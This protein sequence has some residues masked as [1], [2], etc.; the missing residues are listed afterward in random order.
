M[1]LS[2]RLNTLRRQAGVTPERRT[3]DEVV[4]DG[5]GPSGSA[6][7]GSEAGPADAAGGTAPGI[8]SGQETGSMTDASADPGGASGN[9]GSV[10]EGRAPATGQGE[11]PQRARALAELRERIRRMGAAPKQPSAQDVRHSAVSPADGK[12]DG[13]TAPTAIPNGPAVSVDELAERLGGSRIG[14]HVILL[15]RELPPGH[16]H[17]R[18]ALGEALESA[19]PFW[20]AGE[21]VGF[22]DTETTGLAGGAGT[23][24]FLV[25][26]ATP[27][28]EGLRLRQWLMTAF[29]GE[30][31]M[32]ESVDAALAGCERLVSYNGKTFDLPLL[33]DRR[34][35]QRRN[36]PADSAHTDFLHPVRA[37][38]GHAWP[39]CRL[40][41]AE[42]RLLGLQRTDDLPGSDAPWAWQAYLRFGQAD[43]LQRVV[44]HNADD[45]FSLAVLGPALA[46]V[47]AD[48]PAQLA[49][50]EGAARLLHRLRGPVEA[51]RLLQQCEQRLNPAGRLWL[52]REWR[53]AGVWERAVALWQ[54]LAEQGHPEAIEALAKYHE[55][56]RRDPATALEWARRL[57]DSAA[58][59]ARC[60]RLVQRLGRDAGLLADASPDSAPD[61]PEG[62]PP[63]G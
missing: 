47:L 43:L 21:R 56:Q 34:R 28:G 8:E 41:T 40:R 10:R 31:A 49:S 20:E 19:W 22:I 1:S 38:Y 29:A 45:I 13:A 12:S 53:R 7:G 30:A 36:D 17:G 35:M 2:D 14:E 63:T 46:G 39:D 6:P 37:L 62:W 57:P 27:T 61:R 9:E 59:R 48:P 24:A 15:D 58:A 32:L 60:A 52:A 54:S 42:E 16:E 3:A 4:R 33:R 18:L 25:G 26:L 44:R 11:S 55:H 5:A 23:V 50:P 51:R